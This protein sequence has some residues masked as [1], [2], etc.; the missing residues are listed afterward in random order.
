MANHIKL[1][2]GK[3]PV[4]GK[5]RQ[6]EQKSPP[7]SIRWIGFNFSHQLVDRF[8]K[9]TRLEQLFRLG[10]EKLLAVIL[11]NSVNHQ[12]MVSSL[13]TLWGVQTG[14]H[15]SNKRIVRARGSQHSANWNRAYVPGK[16]VLA[17]PRLAMGSRL[18]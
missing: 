11:R 14:K 2:F 3:L 4:S 6:L 10:H 5:A 12:L 17:K 18:K 1:T 7:S 13:H 15:A 9:F 8:L 16:C